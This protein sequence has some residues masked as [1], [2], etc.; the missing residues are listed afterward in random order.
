MN[1]ELRSKAFSLCS[2]KGHLLDAVPKPFFFHLYHSC[3]FSP[4]FS[5]TSSAGYLDVLEAS[6][7]GDIIETVENR[8]L[9]LGAEQG[10]TK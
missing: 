6:P 9:A 7:G 3:D 5:V 2:P 10:T 8:W 1:L 4:K